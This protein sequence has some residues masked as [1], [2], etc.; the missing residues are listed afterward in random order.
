M[1]FA[2]VVGVGKRGT[3]LHL[4]SSHPGPSQSVV[5][6]LSTEG[7]ELII[8]DSRS[9]EGWRAA[10]CQLHRAWSSCPWF[11]LDVSFLYLTPKPGAVSAVAEANITGGQGGSG[12]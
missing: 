8:S 10:Q 5:L 2:L 12:T 7:P 3:G 9:H 1:I 11:T 4:A 6:I